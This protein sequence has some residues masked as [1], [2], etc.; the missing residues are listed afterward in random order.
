MFIWLIF[1]CFISIEVSMLKKKKNSLKV[2]WYTA[3]RSG[4]SP[5]F[6]INAFLML[7]AHWLANQAKN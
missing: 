4:R 5:L 2:Y 1:R 7:I 3:T 6:D